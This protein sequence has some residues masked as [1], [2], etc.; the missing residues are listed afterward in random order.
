MQK[1][2]KSVHLSDIP[3]VVQTEDHSVDYSDDLWVENLA[4]KKV[5]HLVHRSAVLMA[6]MKAAHLA[7]SWDDHSAGRWAAL[8]VAGRA[9]QT[10]TQTDRQWAQTKA[11]MWDS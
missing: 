11:P 2:Q 4:E 9:R 10:E 5:G 1:A 7:H 8:T 3:W 6:Q